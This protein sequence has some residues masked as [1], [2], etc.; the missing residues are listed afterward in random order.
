MY[1]DQNWNATSWSG[2]G[3]GIGSGRSRDRVGNW[4]VVGKAIGKCWE[5]GEMGGPLTC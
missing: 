2:V 3:I 1:R 4:V 5:I